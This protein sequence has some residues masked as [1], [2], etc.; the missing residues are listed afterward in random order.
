MDGQ[1]G[2]C[3]GVCVFQIANAVLSLLNKPHLFLLLF[4][5][6]PYEGSERDKNAPFSIVPGVRG[7]TTLG[8]IWGETGAQPL[9]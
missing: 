5:F 8:F 9:V 1:I 4:F 2:T 7:T 3:S 6:I